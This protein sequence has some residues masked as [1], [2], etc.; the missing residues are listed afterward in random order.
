MNSDTSEE[1]LTA[2]PPASG[3]RIAP[4]TLMRSP[5]FK[6]VDRSALSCTQWTA[7]ALQT[8]LMNQFAKLLKVHSEA[9]DS[10]KSFDEYGLDSIDAVITTGWLG[11]QLGIDLPPEFLFRHNSVDK[12]V[13]A[14]LNGDYRESSAKNRPNKRVP[15]FLFPGAGGRD[16]QA[17]IR[18]RTHS[19]QIA[20]F[21]VVR[22]GD[23][24]E[25]IEQDLDFEKIV[26][27]VCQHIK[28]IVTEGPLLLAGYSQGGQLAYATALA[29]E[30]IG[31]RVTFVGF[32]DSAPRGPTLDQPPK[33]GLVKSVTDWLRVAKQ[34]IAAKISNKSPGEGR[35]RVIA[36]LWPLRQEPDERRKLLT[37]VTRF[38]HMLCRGMGG[39]RVDVFIQM[40]LFWELWTTWL[41]KNA[42]PQL[43]RAPTF[44]FRSEG[45]GSPS[46]GW[47]AYCSDLT[48]VTVPG[49]HHTMFDMEHLDE[50][51][52]QFIAAVDRVAETSG[53]LEKK[54]A[55]D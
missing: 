50:L 26:S 22:I 44:L 54:S 5:T 6:Q 30:R 18:F 53:T 29:L 14:L 37:R 31:R 20:T 9:L 52:D 27:R 7:S 8:L 46:L 41:E 47:E 4:D 49:D 24:R 34:V 25:W 16:E 36:L 10:S 51:I 32:L 19:A 13:R 55:Q 23:W 33:N 40:R 48:I 38:D 17:L 21:E 28:E 3:G 11:D 15:I 35:I 39:V 43:L 2:S 45:P 42:P 1:N 12:V